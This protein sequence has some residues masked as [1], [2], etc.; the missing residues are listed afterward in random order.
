M[1]ISPTEPEVLRDIGVT[2]SQPEEYGVDVLWQSKLGLVG[3]QRKE[4][5]ND[6]LASVHDGRLNREYAMMKSLDVAVLLL[7]GKG[8]WTSE[9]RLIRGHNGKRHAWDRTQH[10]NY[11]AS[12]QLRGVQVQT[13]DNIRDTIKFVQDLRRWSSKDHHL[14]LD[15]RPAARGTQWGSIENDDYVKY[16]YMSLPGIGPVQADALLQHLGMIFRLDV[17]E[18]ELQTVPGIGKGRAKKIV[19]VFRKD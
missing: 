4:F 8:Q 12:V 17:G 19:R 10:R 18:E 13:T 14:G 2:S 3:I 6:F 11:L 5:P 16:L 15:T 9:G 1:F 7:E